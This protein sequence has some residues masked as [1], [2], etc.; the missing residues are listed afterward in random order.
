LKNEGFVKSSK[1]DQQY[2]SSKIWFHN[3]DFKQ[4]H[5]KQIMLFILSYHV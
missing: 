3:P 4:I 1:E 2:H 5:L